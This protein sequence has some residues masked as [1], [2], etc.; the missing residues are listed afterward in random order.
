MLKTAQEEFYVVT[1]LFE[2]ECEIYGYK[3]GKT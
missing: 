3:L 1:P 2:L